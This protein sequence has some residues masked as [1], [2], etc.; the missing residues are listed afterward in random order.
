M[1][2]LD[3]YER[4]ARLIPGLLAVSLLGT[5][6]PQNLHDPGPNMTPQFVHRHLRSP[7]PCPCRV[8]ASRIR[9]S[10][11]CAA[12]L[13]IAATTWLPCGT[14]NSGAFTRLERWNCR[15]SLYTLRFTSFVYGMSTVFRVPE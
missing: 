4:R 14:W 7:R 8:A 1:L 10:A 13:T 3:E 9:Y 5:A 2:W 12:A 15:P 6:S 11:C